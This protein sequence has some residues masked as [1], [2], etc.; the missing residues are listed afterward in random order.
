MFTYYHCDSQYAGRL[1]VPYLLILSS[2]IYGFYNFRYSQIEHLYNLTEKVGSYIHKQSDRF[3]VYCVD[4]QYSLLC[5]LCISIRNMI[6]DWIYENRS[7]R[8]RQ[9]V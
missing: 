7:Y 6:C 3:Y 9:E 1:A 4:V 5:T 2:Y 8:P